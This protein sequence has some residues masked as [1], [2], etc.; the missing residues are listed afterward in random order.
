MAVSALVTIDSLEA[1][2]DVE[3][4]NEIASLHPDSKLLLHDIVLVIDAT[5]I[6]PSTSQAS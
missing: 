2:T 6:S 4:A 1:M 5:L 3:Y